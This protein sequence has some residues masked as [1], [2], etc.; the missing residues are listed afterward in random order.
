ME[1]NCIGKVLKVFTN[2][3]T[4]GSNDDKRNVFGVFKY[5][6]NNVYYVVYSDIKNTYNIVYYGSCYIK[7][8]S[9]IV[10]EAK[11]KEHGEIIK[12]FIYKIVNKEELSQYEIVNLDT[13]ETIEIVG[14]SK[15]EVKTD[16]EKSLVDI[17][18]PKQIDV[19]VSNENN[20]KKKSPFAII[21]LLLVIMMGGFGYY[22]FKSNNKVSDDIMG[23]IVCKKSYS[24]NELPAVVNEERTFNFDSND[25]LMYINNY[26]NYVFNNSDDY[27]DFVSK[28]LYFK[29][30]P[31]D[32]DGGYNLDDDKM[33]YSV[34]YKENIGSNYSYP[35]DYEEV[36]TYYNNAGYVCEE[37]N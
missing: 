28:G 11:E 20:S 13:I 1:N 2:E 14:Y 7:N 32:N 9:I 24:H 5:K 25:S 29:Y 36:L 21:M 6:K 34:S 18:I 23:V 26:N 15:L 19:V 4:F 8:D 16:I 31:N 35:T 27:F 37:K 10:L 17:T 22:Y 33:T 3:L 12:E 30:A